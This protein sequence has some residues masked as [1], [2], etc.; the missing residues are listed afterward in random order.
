MPVL[1]NVRASHTLYEALDRSAA[2]MKIFH[3]HGLWLLPNIYPA[4]VA[5]RHKLP[6]VVSPRGMLGREALRFS[7][8]RKLAFWYALQGSALRSAT[9]FHVTSEQEYCDVRGAGLHQPV[10][11]VPNGIDLPQQRAIVKS[12]HR[13]KTV[14]FLG[15]IHRKKGIDILVEAWSKLED[16]FPDWH[17]NIV[18]PLSNN[19][20]AKKLQ[21][22]IDGGKLARAKLAGPLY[23]ASKSNAY[24]EADLFILPTLNDNFAMTVAEA[25]AHGTPV[26][27]TKGAPWRDLETNGCGWW[28]DH[29]VQALASTLSRAMS[30]DRHRLAEMGQAGR[31]WMERDFSWNSV[32]RSMESVYRWVTRSGERPRCITTA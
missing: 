11:I 7:R 22:M 6:F 23:G 12:A 24:V 30:V 25:L 10:A 1:A 2:E 20:Y 27:S 17:L 5:R 18:G 13:P 15:R 9:C 4:W 32:A 29:G 14:L 28:I 3:T 26:I 31:A 16:K 8:F 19:D 21:R